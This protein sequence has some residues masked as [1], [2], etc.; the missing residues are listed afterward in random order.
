[1]YNVPDSYLDAF[2]T[3]SRQIA[4][5]I[6]VTTNSGLIRIDPDA[7]LVKFTIEKTSPKGKLFGFAVSQKITIESLGILDNIKK[8]NKLEPYIYSKDEDYRVNLPY[9]YVDT[10]EFNKVKNITT[11]VGY[12]ILHKLDKVSISEFNFTYPVN[13]LNYALDILEPV[14]SYAVFDGIN[15]LIRYAP[16]LSG[17]ESA[18]SVLAALAEYTGSICYVTYGDTV[19]FRAIKS[20]DFSDVILPDDYFDLTTGE[21]FTLTQVVS[22]TELGD[23]AASGVEGYTQVLWENPFLNT[24]DNAQSAVTTIANQ[25]RNTSNVN[26]KLSWRGCPAYEL[27]DYVLLQDKDGSTHYVRYFNEVLEY[28]GG[29]KATSDWDPG[30]TENADV[31]PTNI[32]TTLKQTYAKVDKA[33]QQITLLSSS[34]TDALVKTSTLQVTTDE[35][36][37]EVSAVSQ[38][39]NGLSQ[40]V[41]ASVTAE[42]LRIE[43]QKALEEGIDTEVTSVTTTTG[44]TFNEVGLT[45]DKSDSELSTT[46]TEDG[47]FIENSGEV[48]LTADHIG[49]KAANLHSTTYL[50][51]GA[52]S[53]LEDY[54]GNRT[55]CYWIGSE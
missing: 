19:R 31:S 43:I 55:G 40:K 53:R 34:V 41:E 17:N 13:A 11:I 27:G 26:Y 23:N 1:M 39:V 22:S 46:I 24:N 47:M 35:I 38:E 8:G 36:K 25:V 9:F 30:E 28:N 42:E 45:I 44:F 51:I 10:I 52:N 20:E 2:K 3:P 6:N 15:Q 7:S 12:D 50:I 16:N 32:S 33:N 54:N 21:I 4:G 18:R 49:V 29:L 48:V 14:G 37:A 5:Y